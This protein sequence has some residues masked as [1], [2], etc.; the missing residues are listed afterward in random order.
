VKRIACVCGSLVEGDDDDELWENAL[1]H[2]STDHPELEGK[3]S[4]EDILAQAEEI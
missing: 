4:R 2:L 3:V 1:H